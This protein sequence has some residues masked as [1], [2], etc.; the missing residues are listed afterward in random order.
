MRKT[1]SFMACAYSHLLTVVGYPLSVVC[2]VLSATSCHSTQ[3]VPQIVEHTVHDTLY[4][5][6]QQY[7]SIY[8]RE[9]HSQELRPALPQ[10]ETTSSMCN[11]L[12]DTLIMRDVSVEYRYRLLRD[13]VYKARSDTIPVIRT[14]EVVKTERHTPWYAKLLSGWG[15]ITLGMLAFFLVRRFR[16]IM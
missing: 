8:I 16:G 13:T 12:A 14:I 7:D 9:A 4:M 2:Y 15:L 6:S 3:Y 5:N 11:K 1:S 10:P